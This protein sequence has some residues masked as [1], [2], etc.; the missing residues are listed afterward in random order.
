MNTLYYMYSWYYIPVVQTFIPFCSLVCLNLGMI[1]FIKK[2][3]REYLRSFGNRWAVVQCGN[4]AY[5]G[6]AHHARHASPTTRA[7]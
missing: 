2:R 3:G 4:E 6:A 1:Y 7:C 5:R